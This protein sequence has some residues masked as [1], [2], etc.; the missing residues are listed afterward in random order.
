MTAEVLQALRSVRFIAQ[1]IKD[2]DKDN[3]VSFCFHIFIVFLSLGPMN[4]L[5]DIQLSIT[6][7]NEPNC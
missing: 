4:V 1:H 3:E 5:V 6:I 2:A 7:S